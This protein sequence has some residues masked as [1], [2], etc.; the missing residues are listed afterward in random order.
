MAALAKISSATE[1]RARSLFAPSNAGLRANRTNLCQPRFRKSRTLEKRDLRPG[2]EVG[3]K[4]SECGCR[5]VSETP[6]LP[7]MRGKYG[8]SCRDRGG[9]RIAGMRG[10]GGRIRISAW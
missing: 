10:W 2:A 5:R 4:A 7:L 8:P 3:E 1:A 9:P 6:R